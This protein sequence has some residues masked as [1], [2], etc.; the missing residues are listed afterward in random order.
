MK[1]LMYTYM[2]V[3]NVK[4]SQNQPYVINE[5]PSMK[6]KIYYILACTGADINICTFDCNGYTN[7]KS[8]LL[9]PDCPN[10]RHPA[11]LI[12]GMGGMHLLARH[13]MR[14]YTATG[15]SVVCPRYRVSST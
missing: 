2:W 8:Q 10:A 1:N 9:S 6:N 7:C 12:C 5:C 14:V 4:N 13:L 15:C 3:G 11:E